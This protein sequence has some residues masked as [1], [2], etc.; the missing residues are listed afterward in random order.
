MQ[1][2]LL[3][4]PRKYLGLVDRWAINSK[5]WAVA[6]GSGGWQKVVDKNYMAVGKGGHASELPIDIGIKSHLVS[7]TLCPNYK[8][9]VFHRTVTLKGPPPLHGTFFPGTRYAHPW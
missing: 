3:Y 9:A 2:A 6:V 5:Q 1:L 4:F 8:F 7:K